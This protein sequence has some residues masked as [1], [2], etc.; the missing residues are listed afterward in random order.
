ML[1][2]IYGHFSYLPIV[3]FLTVII[4][5]NKN[6]IDTVFLSLKQNKVMD[7]LIEINRSFHLRSKE[8]SF[9]NYEQ[10]RRH[11][12]TMNKT[13]AILKEQNSRHS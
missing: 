13:A 11:F 6:I 3:V 4:L 7:I 2:D 9:K 8:P 1:K 12:K 5:F 10:N